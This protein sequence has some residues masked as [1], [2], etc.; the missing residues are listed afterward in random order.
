M[1][2]KITPEQLKKYR[3][4]KGY[5]QE[6][7]AKRTGTTQQTISNFETG[8]NDTKIIVIDDFFKVVDA[9]L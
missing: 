1:I 3:K 4:I 8:R 6:E 9:D 2:Q 7:F 5:S